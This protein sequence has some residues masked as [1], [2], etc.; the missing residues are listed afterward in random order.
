MSALV[1]HAS[2]DALPFEITFLR[3]ICSDVGGSRMTRRAGFGVTLPCSSAGQW[4]SRVGGHFLVDLMFGFWER[5]VRRNDR[6]VSGSSSVSLT[7]MDFGG[8]GSVALPPDTWQEW[9]R[10]GLRVS[11]GAR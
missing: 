8:A 6:S 3:I 11:V 5:E 10:L 7:L 1:A 9:V 2:L 4:V